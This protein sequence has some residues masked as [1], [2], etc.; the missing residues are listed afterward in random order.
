LE[1]DTAT[2]PRPHYVTTEGGQVRLWLAGQGATL[3]ALPGLIRSA[4]TVA[5]DLARTCP[6]WRIVSVELPGIGYSAGAGLAGVSD[7]ADR[8]A[9]ALSWLGDAPCALLAHDLAAPL[10]RLLPAALAA[11]SGPGVDA[12]FTLGR[13]TAHGWTSAG[14]APPDIAPREDGTHLPALWAFLRD[15][16]LLVPDDPGV[17]LAEGP[18]VPPVEDLSTAF[19][20]AARDPDGFAAAWRLCMNALR[21]DAAGAAGDLA[22]E[23]DLPGALPRLPECR[24][25]PLPTAPMPDNLLW[26]DYAE[27][28]RGRLHLRRAGANGT[29]LLVIPSGGGSCEQFAPV[30]TGLAEGRR[31]FAVDYPGNGLSDPPRGPVSIASLARD[32]VALLDAMKIETTDIWGSHTGAL[33]ALEIALI[34]PGRVGRI[35]MEGPVFI[36]PGFQGDILSNYFIDFSPDKWGRHLL[37]VWNWRRD[38]FMYWPWYRVERAAARQL[39]VPDAGQIHMYALGILESGDTY[40]RAYRSAFSYGTRA[41]LPDLIRP[42]L[43]CAG[44]NDQLKNAVEEAPRVAPPDLV[45]V[46]ETPTT[47]WWPDPDP[48]EADETLA[49]YDA[50][51]RGGDGGDG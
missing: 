4:E 28:A 16:H 49:I 22:G 45:D 19:V 12:T 5:R 37:S 36:D 8:I 44:P 24:A 50:F 32:M 23:G 20:S 25:T 33:V 14:I 2:A 26:N 41:R 6:G 38:M 42:A 47:V 17:P 18:P 1:P 34:A 35:V 13:D 15:R 27:T 48:A 30:V 31:V 51:L 7:M 40:D 29:P 11:R 9:G 3:I 10:A 43:V 39:G 46:A 21:A